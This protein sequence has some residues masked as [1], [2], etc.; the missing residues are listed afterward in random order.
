MHNE[1]LYDLYSSPNVIQVIKSRWMRW[2]WVG[3][4]TGVGFWWGNLRERHHFEDLGIYE[5]I[6]LKWVLKK[7]GRRVLTGFIWFTAGNG[8]RLLQTQIP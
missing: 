1:E 5:R 3:Y 6:I 2:R 7:W 8:G 4:V